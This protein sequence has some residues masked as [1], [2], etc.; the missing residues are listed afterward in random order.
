MIRSGC[1]AA[2]LALPS[3][4]LV[5]GCE[6][7][8]VAV[9][10]GAWQGYLEGETVWIAPPLA[11]RLDVLAVARGDQVTKGQ[12]L[13]ALEREAEEAARREAEQR[14]REAEARLADLEKGRRPTELAELQ[15]A[16][17]QARAQAK[18]AVVE[19]ARAQRLRTEAIVPQ[20][21]VDKAVFARERADQ[22]VVELEQRLATARLG[23]RD[24]AVDAA[25]AAVAAARA[26]LER[27]E[28][29]VSHKRVAAPQDGLVQD[30]LYRVGE[31][32]AAGGP[33]VALLPPGSI[34]VRFFVPEGQLAQVTSGTTLQVS[35][36]GRPPLPARV[37]YVAPQPEYTP[38]VLYNRD[39]RQKLVFLVEGSFLDPSAPDLHPGQPVDVTRGP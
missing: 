28:W 25:R 5:V 9:A 2:L 26:A 31:Q 24:D 12:P 38:P 19:V 29:A 3:L 17:E 10:A 30:T 21:E 18:L 7:R 16:I 20:D 39:N 32:V 36:S 34:K 6:T 33:V 11:G 8:P 37:S 14:L 22:L 15:A 1:V 23:G 27:A 13:F 4:V 35:I